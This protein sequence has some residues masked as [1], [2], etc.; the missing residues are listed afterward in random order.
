MGEVISILR[1]RLESEQLLQGELERARRE[2]KV[3]HPEE[4]DVVA[5]W[6][7]FPGGAM[8]VGPRI[9]KKRQERIA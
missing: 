5:F 7:G 4:A 9:V 1:H 6:I 2:Y 3:E 8:Y